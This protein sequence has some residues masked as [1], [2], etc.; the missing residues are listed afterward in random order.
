M[1]L[2]THLLTHLLH[3][4]AAIGAH[5]VELDISFWSCGRGLT[6]AA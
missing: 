6:Q 3:T 5:V 2:P 4:L 1:E